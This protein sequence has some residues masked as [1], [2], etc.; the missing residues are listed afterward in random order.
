[1]GKLQVF[2]VIFDGGVDLFRAGEWVQGHVRI[3]LSQPKSDIRGIQIKYKGKGK[4]HWTETETHGS[5]DDRRTETVHYYMK[6]K[7]FEEKMLILGR[8]KSEK[9]E[10][11]HLDAGE[12]NFPFR[13][14]IPATPLPHAFEGR[15]GRIRYKVRAKID[16]PWKFD[17]TVEKLFNIVGV[18]VDLNTRPEAPMP[19][20][21]QDEKT[22]CCLCCASGPIKA[23][24]QT[25]KS[26]Y[27][28]GE[29]IWVSGFIENNSSREICDITAK[30]YQKVHFRAKRHGHGWEHHREQKTNLG[31]QRGE[32]C[33]EHRTASFDR[34]PFL[35][36]SCPP[37]GLDGCDIMS[38][39]YY[40]E[41]EADVSGTPFDLELKLPITIGT[42]PLYSAYYSAAFPPG[43]VVT[44]QPTAPPSE[45]PP[46]SYEVAMGGPQ[47]IPSKSG[48]D[49]TFGKMMYAPKYPYYSFPNAGDPA[50]P[51]P[52]QSMYPPV[53]GDP[54]HP[55]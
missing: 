52:A 12:H 47:E 54:A 13:F 45:P 46:P 29:T 14:Q 22:I 3:V 41:F 51:P 18:P 1:M 34:K 8:D 50:Y 49:Y 38:I 40:I 11:V 24:A 42:V 43:E 36:P 23:S 37:S 6:E 28:P 17:H 5:G 27:V 53:Q 32:G 25:D 26:G 35:V 9:G 39:E 2:E 4:T 30:F 48:H 21:S 31:E 55:S 15:Y 7:Y 10:K 33:G 16:R 19:S 44:Q 20:A